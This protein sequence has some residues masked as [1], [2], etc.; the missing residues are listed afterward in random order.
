MIRRIKIKQYR[1]L[2]QLE[3]NFNE[4]INVISG[5]NGTCKTSLLHM[6]SNSFQAP[7]K[8]YEDLSDSS[9]LEIIRRV[10]DITNPKIETLTR[11]D[12]QYND[13]ANGEKGSL[14]VVDYFN[15]QSLEF[16]KHNSKMNNRYAIKPIYSKGKHESLPVCPIIY[17][18]LTRLYPFGEFQRDE[19][20]E[21]IK[22]TL[23]DNYQ[24]EIAEV[25]N[26]LTGIKILKYASQKM[27]DIKV[28][29]DFLSDKEG[30]DS[31]TIS[32]GED[33]LF[34]LI[35]AIISLKYYAESLILKDN[36]YSI[37]L[38]DEFDATLHPSL[39]IKLLEVFRDYAKN[40]KIQIISTTHSLYLL[41]EALTKKDNVIYLIDN[42]TSVCP[43]EDVDIY[44]IKMYLHNKTRSQI[45]MG[46]F[47]PVFTED[48]EARIFLKIL[49]NYFSDQNTNFASVSRY[50]HFVDANISAKNL[51]N[52]FNDTYLLNSTMQSICILDGDQRGQGDY[53]KYIILLPGGNSP[54]QLIMDYSVK[55]YDDDDA[56]WTDPDI[57]DFNFGKKYYRDNIHSE[58]KEI[59]EKI[60]KAES[61]HGLQRKLNKDFFNKNERF[62]EI[63]FMHWVKNPKN[64]IMIEKFYKDLNIIFKKTATFHGINP[65]EW[66]I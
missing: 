44:K 10:N 17:L 47:I 31:N 24:D 32:A 20:I 29:P 45:Y 28:R 42:I 25:Y 14:F 38:I 22:K 23:P 21:G 16:R 56:F 57:L 6:V 63:L 62:F 55:L 61:K 30:I 15:S 2:R 37:L 60:E 7:T 50:F 4:G 8:T 26:K 40:Y 66:D 1:K 49:I 35:T 64:K 65:K 19:L 36:G 48:A 27:G 59:K 41:E 51:M 33:N 11:G 53:S 58:I 43:M 5:T 54:E 12:K 18:G 39:Q 9:C 52:I 3:I 46:R 34:I 13:P